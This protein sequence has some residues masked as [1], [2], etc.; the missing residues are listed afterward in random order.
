MEKRE[1]GKEGDPKSGKLGKEGDWETG[2]KS[3]VTAVGM[4]APRCGRGCGRGFGRKNFAPV[5]LRL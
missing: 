3:P 2:K 4:D 1:T 5:W